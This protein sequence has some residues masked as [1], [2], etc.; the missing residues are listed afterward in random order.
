M[1]FSLHTMSKAF[2]ISLYCYYSNVCHVAFRF[3]EFVVSYMITKHWNLFILFLSELHS[4]IR[5]EILAKPSPVIVQ[6]QRVHLRSRPLK[7]I[8]I[9]ST[10]AFYFVPRL[11]ISIQ[12]PTSRINSESNYWH[13][14]GQIYMKRERVTARWKSLSRA[15][16]E[17]FR[18]HEGKFLCTISVR[19]G[20]KL[21]LITGGRRNS[22]RHPSRDEIRSRNAHYTQCTP[23]KSPGTPHDGR[24]YPRL[25]REPRGIRSGLLRMI[26]GIFHHRSQITWKTNRC[27][28]RHVK[29]RH[30]PRCYRIQ[31]ANPEWIRPGE[32]MMVFA[33]ID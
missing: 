7:F 31:I 10:K 24:S 18:S 20:E 5:E 27:R 15:H 32:L 11:L 3:N 22:P 17:G 1:F 12:V 30:V 23:L 2:P 21:W 33:G 28:A 16:L 9:R 25:P 29:S 14:F 8:P 6:A 4:R 13:M 19:R 26:I